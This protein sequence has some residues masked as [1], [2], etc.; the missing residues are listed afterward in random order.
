MN[1]PRLILADEPTGDLDEDTERDMMNFFTTMNRAE[2]ITFIMV[3]HNTDLAQ[4]TRRRLRMHQG[5]LQEQ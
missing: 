2:G 5:Q 4:Q 1:G 3:T